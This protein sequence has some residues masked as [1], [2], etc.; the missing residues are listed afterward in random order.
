MTEDQLEED[1]LVWLADVRYRSVYGPEIAVDDA[2][3]EIRDDFVRLPNVM[4]KF[5]KAAA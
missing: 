3:G 1:T 4:E 2:S 5:E